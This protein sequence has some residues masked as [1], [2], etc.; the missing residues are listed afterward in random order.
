M[1]KRYFKGALTVHPEQLQAALECRWEGFPLSPDLILFLILYV[2]AFL[3]SN[4]AFGGT[5]QSPEQ[6]LRN[7]ISQLKILL[8]ECRP[9]RWWVQVSKPTTRP[10]GQTMI[11]SGP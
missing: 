11:S 2:K 3:K 7:T 4:Y 5:Y 10:T 8:R 9:G 1:F 6:D